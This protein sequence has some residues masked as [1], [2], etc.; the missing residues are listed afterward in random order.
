ME[1][2]HA[3]IEHLYA[4]PPVL[5]YRPEAVI[6][7]LP[8]SSQSSNVSALCYNL[9]EPLGSEEANPEISS[10]A[11]IPDQGHHIVSGKFVSSL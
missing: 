7:T 8:Q 10:S 2:T 1:V 6:A 4:E 9:V 3:E 11:L 5:A